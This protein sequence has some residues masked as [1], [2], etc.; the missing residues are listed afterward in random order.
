[1]NPWRDMADEKGQITIEKFEQAFTLDLNQV[2]NFYRQHWTEPLAAIGLSGDSLIE[3][4]RD[5]IG[6]VEQV[7]VF[8]LEDALGGGIPGAWVPAL[9]SGL[10][11]I[12]PRGKSREITFL[13]AGAKE[14]F[15]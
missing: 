2:L 14:L 9:G 1:M 12:A 7:P 10:R 6:K 3:E 11:G 15:E 5:V 8:M 13:G 4:A